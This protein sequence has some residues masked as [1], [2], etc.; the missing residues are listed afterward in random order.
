MRCSRRRGG[1]PAAQ[2][3]RHA[4]VGGLAEPAFGYLVAAG[5]QAMEV[6]AAQDA[7]EQYERARSLLAKEDVRTGGGQLV[8]ASIPELEHLYTQLGRAYEL[9]NEWGKAQAA[10]ETMLALGQQLGEARLEVV[11]LNHLAILAFH[12]EADP[13]R[14]EALLEEARGVAEEA[15][16]K[17]ALVETEC[18]LADVMTYGV[19]EFEPSGPLARKALASARAL[20]EE[21]PDLVARAL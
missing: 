16:L 8:E 5:D 18:T 2:L 21:R 14:A 13:P 7:I 12:Q 1:A 17:E 3:A 6:F 11:S 9:T 20:E 4:L 15:G 19:G 10:Y